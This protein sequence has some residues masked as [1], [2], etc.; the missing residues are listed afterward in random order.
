MSADSVATMQ[1]KGTLVLAQEFYQWL[2]ENTKVEPVEPVS[3]D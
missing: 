3:N 2:T 1:M